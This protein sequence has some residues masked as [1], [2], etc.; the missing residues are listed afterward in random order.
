MRVRNFIKKNYKIGIG[1]MI[2]LIISIVGVYASDTTSS[3]DVVY[4]NSTS[5]LKSTNMQDAIDELNT[6]ATKSCK[7]IKGTGRNTNDEI[8]CGT[9]EF[10]VLYT[11]G[12]SI[13]VLTK[14]P[15]DSGIKTFSYND[16]TGPSFTYI[17]NPTYAQNKNC[18]NNNYL[19]ASRKSPSS[20]SDIL[21]KYREV[22]NRIGLSDEIEVLTPSIE[23]LNKAGCNFSTS[24]YYT[25][26]NGTCTSLSWLQAVVLT[27]YMGGPNTNVVASTT[28]LGYAPANQFG[29]T[30]IYEKLMVKIPIKNILILNS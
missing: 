16:T 7:V 5:G 28:G 2:G 11:S 13:N 23:D 9:E 22:L 18:G 20:T 26:D 19:C 6:K 27:D 14:Y 4:N 12:D 25:S 3:L 21:P 10:Y 30:A 24:P 1:V 17:E 15:I 8:A 29:H